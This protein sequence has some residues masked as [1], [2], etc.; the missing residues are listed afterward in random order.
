MNVGVYL[1]KYINSRRFFSDNFTGFKFCDS[2]NFP[3]FSKLIQWEAILKQVPTDFR[4]SEVFGGTL[5]CT[6]LGPKTDFQHN[7]YIF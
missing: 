5:N 3:S 2:L 4:D 7:F 1:Y 6:I